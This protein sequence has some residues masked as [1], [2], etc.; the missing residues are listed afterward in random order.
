MEG[1]M[2]LAL[3][4]ELHTHLN[5]FICS[6]LQAYEGR[7]VCEFRLLGWQYLLNKSFCDLEKKSHV[8]L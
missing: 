4:S 7:I 8:I 5:F 3:E 2:Y 6:I 1:C